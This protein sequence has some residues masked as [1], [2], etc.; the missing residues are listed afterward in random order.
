MENL[1]L[2]PASCEDEDLLL[3]WA[4][5]PE[6]R[7]NSFQTKMITVE[8]HKKWFRRMMEDPREIQYILMSDGVPAGQVRISC[9]GGTA[10]INYSISADFRGRGYGEKL[11]QLVRQ[12]VV[13]DY[14]EIRTLIGKVKPGNV[15]SEKCFSRNEF[16]ITYS[17]FEYEIHRNQNEQDAAVDYEVDKMGE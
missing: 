2:R 8:E 4:N 11:I 16:K 5:N 7:Q 14:P 10:E 13:R 1:Y 9:N 17:C 3:I 6:V 15:A 12:E